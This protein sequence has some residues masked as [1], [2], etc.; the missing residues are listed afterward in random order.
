M[1]SY[2]M[3]Y[4]LGG[5]AEIEVN[6]ERVTITE[7]QCLITEQATLSMRTRDSVKIMGIQILKNRD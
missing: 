6:L 5:E 3:F 4:V 1:T 2:V 7:G